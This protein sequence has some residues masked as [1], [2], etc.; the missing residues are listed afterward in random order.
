MLKK[1]NCP[2]KQATK[3]KTKNRQKAIDKTDGKVTV[4]LDWPSDLHSFQGHKISH[5][6]MIQYGLHFTWSIYLQLEFTI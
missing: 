1:I 2:I 6:Y 3:N 4:K 5:W